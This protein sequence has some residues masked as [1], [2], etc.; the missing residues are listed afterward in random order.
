MTYG[1]K[2]AYTGTA[3]DN[4]VITGNL[5]VCREFYLQIFSTQC[6]VQEP[7]CKNDVTI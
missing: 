2:N 6:S 3:G 1:T 4:I 7:S 5:R